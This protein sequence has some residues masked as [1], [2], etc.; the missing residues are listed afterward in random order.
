MPTIYQANEELITILE[1]HGFIETTAKSERIRGKKCFKLSKSAR[2]EIYFDYINIKI[3]DSFRLMES[4]TQLNSKELKSLLLYFKLKKAEFKELVPEG[5]FNFKKTEESLTSLAEELEKL[6][7]LE[8][9]NPRQVRINRI[10]D[11]YE[12]IIIE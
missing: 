3:E 10:L 4:R 6:K 2:K 1:K 5:G 12:S 8:I 11:I 7:N 9:N